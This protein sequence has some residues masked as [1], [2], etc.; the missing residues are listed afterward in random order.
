MTYV[1]LATHQIPTAAVNFPISLWGRQVRD[2]QE[3]MLRPL[4]ALADGE[5]AKVGG[6]YVATG[7][8]TLPATA[9]PG[10]M[11]RLTV[12]TGG[13]MSV[14]INGTLRDYTGG[15]RV[16]LT[17]DGS[18]WHQD[19][20]PV[21]FLSRDFGGDLVAALTSD[22]AWLVVDQDASYAP[23]IEVPDTIK[24]EGIGNPILT[25]TGGHAGPAIEFQGDVEISG[26]TFDGGGHSFIDGAETGMIDYGAQVNETDVHYRSVNG[27]E[28]HKQYGSAYYL[29]AHTEHRGCSW[30]NITTVT[31][32][33]GIGG[34]CG[35]AWISNNSDGADDLA[36][37]SHLFDA[38]LFSDIWT[39]RNGGGLLFPDSD[40]VRVFFY[41]DAGDAA[42]TTA[43]QAALDRTQVTIRDSLFR[44]VLKSAAKLQ[45][46]V[47]RTIGNLIWV[48][49]LKAEGQT[50]VL[51]G[52][53]YQL[54]SSYRSTD[55]KVLGAFENGVVAQ[56]DI[57]SVVGFHFDSSTSGAL[58]VNAG[59]SG[60]TTDQVNVENVTVDGAYSVV[61]MNSGS[62]LLDG[63]RLGSKFGQADNDGAVVEFQRGHSVSISGVV[64][65]AVTE[66]ISIVRGRNTTSFMTGD[67]KVVDVKGSSPV[68]SQG[69]IA[70]NTVGYFQGSIRVESVEW[71]G[72]FSGPALFIGDGPSATPAA[73]SLETRNNRFEDTGTEAIQ[74]MARIDGAPLAYWKSVGDTFVTSNPNTSSRVIYAFHDGLAEFVGLYVHNTTGTLLVLLETS[75]NRQTVARGCTFR[76]EVTTGTVNRAVKLGATDEVISSDLLID[77]HET[78][79]LVLAATALKRIDN[80]TARTTGTAVAASGGTGLTE[81]GT[82]TF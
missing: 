20:S 11:V 42:R 52:F 10:D 16:D 33:G 22:V 15:Q 56:G 80:V 6:S 34:F 77:C 82:V 43:N 55:D 53:R 41:E 57:N 75:S 19:A 29:G 4:G 64:A 2:N 23:G 12:A 5:T 14:S 37:V 72:A 59:S 68:A 3:V 25:A 7:T 17:Y 35:G 61:A 76:D 69:L 65:D 48:D 66:P 54:G 70:S 18:D 51:T 26:V 46:I 49:D 32:T 36:P 45:S 50:S 62:L 79:L 27:A 28:N 39:K 81:A 38:C 63:A 1:D 73:T 21:R 67:L 44:N 8:V 24:V 60:V 71:V 47:G 31:D 58:A 9:D 30:S 78:Q 13:S 74:Y 40:G